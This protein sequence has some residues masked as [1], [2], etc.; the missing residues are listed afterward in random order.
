M[1]VLK[2]NP[3]TYIVEIVKSL[4]LFL[5]K[6]LGDYKAVFSA[7]KDLL[8]QC[9]IIEAVCDYEQAIWIGIRHAFPL[10]KTI[11][12][13]FH[14]VQAVWKHVKHVQHTGTTN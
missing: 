1:H 13:A 10:S 14:W 8:P 11:G 5:A 7:I 4:N 6:I 2:H 3:F 9:N 12:C